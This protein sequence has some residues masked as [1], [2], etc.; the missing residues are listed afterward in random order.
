MKT[1]DDANFTPNSKKEPYISHC[2]ELEGGQDRR[3]I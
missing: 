2:K 3:S 1:L